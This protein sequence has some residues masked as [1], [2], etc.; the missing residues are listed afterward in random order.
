[1]M[2]KIVCAQTARGLRVLMAAAAFAISGPLFAQQA[3]PTPEAAANALVNAIATSDHDALKQV[4]GPQYPSLLPEEGVHRDDIYAFLGAWAKQHTIEQAGDKRAVLAVGET[5]WTFPIPIAKTGNGWKFDLHA[6]Q[7]ELSTRRIGRNE[8]DT[9]AMLRQLGDAQEKYAAEV[10]GGG[11]A[12]RLVSRAGKT[13][14]LYW[15]ADSDDDKSPLGPDALV[16]GPETPAAEAYHGY[17]YR[18]ITPGKGSDAKYVFVAWPVAYGKTGT[19]TFA[20]DSSGTVYQR[21]LGPSTASR[22]KAMGTFSPGAG[23]GKVE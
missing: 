22:A 4:L 17:H 14:G 13:D 7:Q 21:D 18:I 1:M 8:L 3:Y 20:L 5:G 2:R 16:M 15:P 11:Y 9:I 23:W 10:G 12:R 19:L 6:G